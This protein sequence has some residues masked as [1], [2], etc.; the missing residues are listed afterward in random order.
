LD[1]KNLR[2]VYLDT[3]IENLLDWNFAND[4][5]TGKIATHDEL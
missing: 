1:H 4:Q 3:L 2:G 5:Y